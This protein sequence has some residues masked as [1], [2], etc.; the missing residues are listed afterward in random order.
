MPE[1]L[2]RRIA[3]LRVQHGWTQQELAER[4]AISRVAVSHLESGISVPSERTVTLLA[5]LFKREPDA[6]VAGTSYPNAKAERLPPVA[7]RYTEAELLSR[8]LDADLNW[9]ELLRGTPGWQGFALDTGQRWLVQLEPLTG[10][11]DARERVLIVS[12][13]ERA[14]ALIQSVLAP[15]T[16]PH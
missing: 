9:L 6:L 14:R 16:H 8:L 15:T 13:L 12:A 3:G 10:S 4:L 2:G 7:C 1:S 11:G 5:G